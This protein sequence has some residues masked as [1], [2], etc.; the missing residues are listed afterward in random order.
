MD[1]AR[2]SGRLRGRRNLRV[3]GALLNGVAIRGSYGVITFI[4]SQQARPRA[5]LN[6]FYIFRLL[7]FSRRITL[8]SSVHDI[9]PNRQRELAPKRATINLLRL[10]E[11]RP[12]SAREIGIISGKQ[13]ISEIVSGARSEEHTSELQ[14]PMYLVCRLLLEKKKK[15]NK[16]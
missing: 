12:H 8:G 5:Y 13:R 10:V 15:K 16:N 7:N 9:D 4:R 2:F 3:S 14:S 1:V 11:P 6:L